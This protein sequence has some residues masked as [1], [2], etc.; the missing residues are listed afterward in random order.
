MTKQRKKK[1]ER[2]GGKCDSSGKCNYSREN[3]KK[4]KLSLLSAFRTEKK[5]E[6]SGIKCH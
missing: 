5:K 1:R 4:K 6:K 2:D 3:L